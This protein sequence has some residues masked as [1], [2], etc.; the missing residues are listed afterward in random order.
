MIITLGH[1]KGGVGK[2]TLALNI[3]I[4]R[5]R[6]GNDVLLVDGDPKQASLSKAVALRGET[7]RSPAL[8]CVLLDDARSL[9]Q[10]IGLLKPKYSDIIIDVGGKDSNALRAALIVTDLLLLP[11]GPESVEIW[12][13]DDILGLVEEARAFNDFQVAA[14]LNRAKA[15]GRDNAEARAIIAEYPDI[16]L[17]PVSLG[18]RSVFS[19]AFGQGLSVAEYRPRNRKAETELAKLVRVLFADFTVK[20][21]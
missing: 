19:S 18:N 15:A 6:Q 9:R 14:V 7:E 4:E 11:V 13:L 21:L 1:T 3:A 16:D 2:S 17:L 12:A 10:Q 5:I 8:P 20:A